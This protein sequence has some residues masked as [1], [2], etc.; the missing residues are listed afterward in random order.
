MI[1]NPKHP[2]NMGKT[3]YTYEGKKKSLGGLSKMFNDLVLVEDEWVEAVR[4]QFRQSGYQHFLHFVKK[5]VRHE[6][7]ID[8]TDAQAWLVIHDIT[9]DGVPM[10]LRDVS[11]D[12]DAN[13]AKILKGA[14]GAVANTVMAPVE[15]TM[16][17]VQAPFK[18]STRDDVIEK[19][20]PNSDPVEE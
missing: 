12:E 6:L 10:A 2:N 19:E 20:L 17:A 8:L 7:S 13:A 15:A 5:M 1:T 3:Y 9:N 4:G 18:K 14:V 11:N 16:Q